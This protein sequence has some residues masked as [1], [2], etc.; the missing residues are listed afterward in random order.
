M[1]AFA[2][3]AIAAVSVAGAAAAS[4]S[5]SWLTS[6]VYPTAAADAVGAAAAKDPTAR[7]YSDVRFAD[8]LL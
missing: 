2:A 1:V 8:W 5:D 6:S 4:R 7:I 3:A